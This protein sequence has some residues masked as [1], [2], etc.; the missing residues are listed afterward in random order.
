MGEQEV[1]NKLGTCWG[2]DHKKERFRVTDD[3]NQKETQGEKKNSTWGG[4]G[5]TLQ[6]KKFPKKRR[7]GTMQRKKK[8]KEKKKDYE[9]CAET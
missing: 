4:E 9:W 3:A 2:G 6:Q 5:G 1:N 7:Q 8:K